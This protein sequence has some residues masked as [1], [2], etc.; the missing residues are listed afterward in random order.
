MDQPERWR[1]WNDRLDDVLSRLNTGRTGL[2]N[3]EADARWG[4]YGP[5]ARVA[6]KRTSAAWQL[7][8][9]LAN[10]LILL[11]VGVSGLAAVV[12]DLSS[13]GIIFVTVLLSVLID[14]VQERQAERTMAALA[15]SVASTTMAFR[16]GRLQEVPV[17]SLVPGDVIALEPGDLVPAD[18]RLIEARD[19]TLNQA[20][21]TG[22]S[23]PAEKIASDAPDGVAA[24]VLA[25]NSVFQSTSV[26][27][28][29]GR[30]VVCMTG[31]AT[32][33]ASLAAS[34][35]ARPPPTAF[36]LS[37]EQF[38]TLMLRLTVVV[39]AVVL[40]ADI[41]LH[42]PLVQSLLFA[43]ALAVA[44]AP[45]LLPA[46]IAVTL[47]RGAQRLA[48]RKVVVKQLAAI[49][50]LGAMDMLCTD[51]TGT[52]TEARME[53]ARSVDVTGADDERPRALAFLNSHFSSGV[54]SP[55]DTAI[56]EQG[57]EPGDWRK[58]DEV[59]FDYQR[60]RIS[61]LLENGSKRTLV[62]KG[63][64]ENVIAVCTSY[65]SME[66]GLLPLDAPMRRQI[67]Q[68]L[69]VLSGQGFRLL[70]VARRD[71]PT[72]KQAAGI[73][74]ESEMVLIGF[75]GFRDPPKRSAGEAIRGLR[76]LGVSV[77]IL[78]GDG[79]IV[80]RRLC[81][82]VGIP[83]SGS[84]SGDELA[85]LS[86]PALLARVEHTNVFCRMNP[87]DKERVISLLRRRG[88]VVGYLGDGVNDAPALHVADVGLSVDGAAAV[89]RE[90]AS[91]I[92]LQHD[93]S[94][95]RDGVMEGRRAIEN[96]TKYVLMGTS[97]NFGNMLS[98]AGAA[99]FLPILPMLPVQVLLNN[100]LYDISELGIPF[101]NVD[102][103]TLSRPVHWRIGII[104]RSMLVFGPVSSIFDLATFG[105]LL[106]LFHAT[107]P[108]FQT[109]WFVESL[110]TQALVIFAIRSRG[111]MLRSRPH[112]LLTALTLGVVATAALLPLSP[113][114]A[115]L[116]FVQLP[117]SYYAFVLGAAIA[118]LAIVEAIKPAV[119]GR[120]PSASADSA[121]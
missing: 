80:T 21:L 63:A 56:L 119:L 117:L 103:E 85:H 82:D 25:E 79:E 45:E 112:P 15:D 106:W 30:A 7:L 73:V 12:G 96:A 6:R 23:Y 13:F 17:T 94:V 29:S 69:A 77:K 26:A 32:E 90:A 93:L 16:D 5:N 27:T 108:E 62:S 111:Q 48:D 1:F 3:I 9:R 2:S 95:V 39:V 75:V 51:K 88:H 58:I 115:L 92:L 110:A 42:R 57:G 61:V 50:N 91:L 74:D 114:G 35:E 41:I 46:I 107:A 64:P 109:G 38:G 37:L 72:D 81:E 121:P 53:L 116:G 49:H 78:T 8:K 59:P 120:S 22:E 36:A 24:A 65:E 31:A 104:R 86:E 18:C 60:R 71:Q 99:L 19:L 97:S 87:A 4:R 101:D 98:M 84:I 43:L 70:A 54:M 100:L 14:F 47:A 40:I 28:G 83:I 118:Y 20:L 55:L 68:V 66:L 34:L 67:E 10:P 102:R 44:L 11:L 52:L 76:D 105:V 89:A 113:L 33:L